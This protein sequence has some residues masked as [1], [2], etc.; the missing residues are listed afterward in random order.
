MLN[1]RNTES[2]CGHI[3]GCK[4]SCLGFLESQNTFRFIF[5]DAEKQ[6]NVGHHQPTS[7]KEALPLNTTLSLFRPPQRLI[8]AHKLASA[9]LQYHSTPWLAEDWNLK[10]LAFLGNESE[11]GAD[12]LA[13][14]LET[15]HLSTQFPKKSRTVEYD[16]GGGGPVP[17]APAMEATEATS[18]IQTTNRYT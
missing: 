10:D 15:L 17:I 11:P 2:F 5:Y 7:G 18:R 4:S 3:S 1:L 14:D 9:V 6:A 12:D 16:P 13:K 8:L